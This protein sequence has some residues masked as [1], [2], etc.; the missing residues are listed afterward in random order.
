MKKSNLELLYSKRQTRAKVGI[1]TA[2]IIVFFLVPFSTIFEL[3]WVTPAFYGY[4]SYYKIETTT[5]IINILL[6]YFMVAVLYFIH[7]IILAVVVTNIIS[8]ISKKRKRVLIEIL[9]LFPFTTF[10][11]FCFLLIASDW[12]G[13]EYILGNHVLFSLGLFLIILPS[14]GAFIYFNE[15]YYKQCQGE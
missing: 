7:F 1:K 12:V 2:R 11:F 13:S 14:T 5:I 4:R 15:R 3:F 6:S 8:K 10:H 9:S